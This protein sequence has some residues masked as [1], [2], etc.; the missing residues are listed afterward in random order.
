MDGLQQRVREL[1][2]PYLA[3][4]GDERPTFSVHVERAP[5]DV[6][7][8]LHGDVPHVTA[9][10]MKVPVALTVLRRVAARTLSLD[11]TVVVRSSFP[12]VAGGE[13]VLDAR[14]ESDAPL[15]LR[16]GDRSTVGEL[17]HRMIAVSSN[18]ATDLLLDLVPPAE[19]TAVAHEA[20]ATE[21]RVRRWLCDPAGTPSSTTARDCATLMWAAVQHPALRDALAAQQYNAEIPSGLPPGTRVLHKT[22]WDS[23]VVHDMAYVMPPDAPPFVLAVLSTGFVDAPTAG[24]L[25]GRVARLCWDALVAGSGP[26]PRGGAVHGG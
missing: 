24:V 26:G 20:G 3:V 16:V 5:G 1:L 9:S 14:D 7:L 22:G 11:D 2:D 8:S 19:V 21:T 6:V 25:V 15:H 17:L 18:L 12:S 10:L 23:R 4:Y 13:F